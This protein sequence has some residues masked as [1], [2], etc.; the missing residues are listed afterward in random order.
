MLFVVN[1]IFPGWASRK[2]ENWG[3]GSWCC[4]QLVR[5]RLE[6]WFLGSYPVFRNWEQ[7]ELFDFF[8]PRT[9]TH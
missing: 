4:L 8:F 7:I 1:L 9:K 5:P 6:S 2:W 3:N